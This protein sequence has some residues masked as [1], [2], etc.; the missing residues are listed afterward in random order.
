LSKR[1]QI[2]LIAF[3][4]FGAG[5]CAVPAM[6]KDPLSNDSAAGQ[7]LYVAKCAKCHK[8]YDP[9]KYSEADWEMWMTKMSKK[10]KLKPAQEA[11]LSR[12]ISQNLRPPKNGTNTVPIAK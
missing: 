4:G 3:V 10:A 6:A 2:I 7:K 1:I 9:A 11:E 12:Y 8:F 5:G